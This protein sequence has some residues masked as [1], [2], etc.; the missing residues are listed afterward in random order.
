[1][2]KEISMIDMW[3]KPGDPTITKD[4]SRS[5]TQR[6][7]QENWCYGIE[8]SDDDHGQQACPPSN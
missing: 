1:M 8:E 5:Y 2:V 4:D 6:I 7:F 3:G